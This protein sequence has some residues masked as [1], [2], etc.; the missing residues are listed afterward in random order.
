MIQLGTFICLNND[1]KLLV[2]KFCR[3]NNNFKY[4]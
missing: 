4:P 1:D 2:K 3:Y